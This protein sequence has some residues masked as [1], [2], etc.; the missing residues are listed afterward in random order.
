MWNE[1]TNLEMEQITGGSDKP[2]TT[3]IDVG[4]VIR[5]TTEAVKFV[6]EVSKDLGAAAHDFIGCPKCWFGY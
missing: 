4:D 5:A 2:T 6:Y 3:I 1:M